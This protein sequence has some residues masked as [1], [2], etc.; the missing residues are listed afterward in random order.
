MRLMHLK[1]KHPLEKSKSKTYEEP[2]LLVDWYVV[3]CEK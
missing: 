1:I 3:G 2:N